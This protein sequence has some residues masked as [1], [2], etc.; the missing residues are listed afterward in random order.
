ML[1][2][3]LLFSKIPYMYIFALYLCVVPFPFWPIFVFLKNRSRHEITL[4]CVCSLIAP[5]NCWIPLLAFVKLGKHM[6]LPEAISTEHFK[7]PSHQL[8]QTSTEASQ[9]I[10]V[11]TLIW[12]EC[13]NQLSLHLPRSTNFHF[14]LYY[15]NCSDRKPGD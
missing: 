6:T 5:N 13:L 8:Y 7:N 10:E 2:Q 12:L 11:I 4:L 15:S 1:F 3:H 14:K 9:M